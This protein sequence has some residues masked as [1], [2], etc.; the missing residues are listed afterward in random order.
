M[1]DH[2]QEWTTAKALLPIQRA[3][4]I[5]VMSLFSVTR[6][7]AALTNRKGNLADR[8]LCRLGHSG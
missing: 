8:Q 1:D 6:L 5:M 3:S 4:A 7:K 2:F